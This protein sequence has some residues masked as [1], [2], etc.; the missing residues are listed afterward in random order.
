MSFSFLYSLACVLPA[1]YISS[2]PGVCLKPLWKPSLS[3]LPHAQ[4]CVVVPFPY[5]WP[6]S[7]SL[8]NPQ[9]WITFLASFGVNQVSAC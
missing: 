1:K 8:L 7:Y 2:Q 3:H 5:S 4:C 6:S 9:D